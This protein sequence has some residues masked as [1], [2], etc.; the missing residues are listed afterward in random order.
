MSKRT[1]AKTSHA[2]RHAATHKPSPST[3]TR[4]HPRSVSSLTPE[5][6][7]GEAPDQ[8]FFEGAHDEIDP[9]LRH[10]MISEA[11]YHLYAARNFADGADL[12]D[13]LQAEAG[14]EHLLLDRGD[15]GTDRA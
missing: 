14:V 13:W 1:A 15:A 9:D 12:D 11:A 2:S 4:I 10:R 5:N 7:G 6:D 3:P 8:P